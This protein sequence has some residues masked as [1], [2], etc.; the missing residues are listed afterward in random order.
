[1]CCFI[2]NKFINYIFKNEKLSQKNSKS[3]INFKSKEVRMSNNKNH[4]KVG[5]P[6]IGVFVAMML[7]FMFVFYVFLIP[8]GVSSFVLPLFK[9]TTEEINKNGFA[10]FKG[11]VWATPAGKAKKGGEYNVDREISG[12]DING[13]YIFDFT[14]KLRK[15]EENGKKLD[16]YNKA[17]NEFYLK[18]PGLSESFAIILSPAIA[19]GI[20]AFVAGGLIAFIIALV[21]PSG[22]GL[23]SALFENQ[24]EHIKV[25]IRL[26]TGFSDDVVDILTMPDHKLKDVDRDI[27]EEIFRRVWER[28]ETDTE[29]AK[30]VVLFNDIFDDNTDI[31][32]F[33]NEA[34]YTRIKEY[35][36]EFVLSEIADTRD[37]RA[38]KA[39]HFLIGAGLRL[40][41]AHHFTEK[42]SNNVTGMA[43]AGAAVLIIA[44]GV[45][46]LKFIPAA[47]PSLIFFAI[48]LEFTLLSLMAITIFYTEE[49][50]RMDKM[51][52]KMEDGNKSQLD[53]LRN[54][55]VDIHQLATALMG[56][57]SDIIKQRVENSISEYLSSGDQVQ[58]QIA[59]A[60]ADK[61]VFDIKGGNSSGNSS[62]RRK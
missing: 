17:S 47:Q 50:E 8:L 30:Y 57:T 54:Q 46:G 2:L 14:T 18:A 38:W 10:K 51:M 37:G 28:T 62:S 20:L 22:I 61:I 36:S 29:N 56:Q 15:L 55:Q 6:Q 31:V 44:V 12:E 53:T 19:F 49:E 42:Y 4:V 45:R 3:K 27:A 41:L 59:T 26:Q 25:K 40:Y 60:I 21:M 58:K 33:R 35:F 1:M 48:L 11:L 34:I 39:N 32:F 13:E 24:I 9:P 7:A 16:G 23:I 5:G 52:K 43:Y